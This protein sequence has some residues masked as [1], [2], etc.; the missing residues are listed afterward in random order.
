MGG[1][2]H[3]RSMNI[4]GPSAYEVMECFHQVFDATYNNGI[5]L[6]LS[7]GTA[8][9]GEVS[10]H[11]ASADEAHVYSDKTLRGAMLACLTGIERKASPS[12]EA[13][14]RVVRARVEGWPDE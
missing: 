5:P 4:K 6:S 12:M 14:I 7:L 8:T 11:S 1:R 2:V 3:D 10:I 9:C 13:R